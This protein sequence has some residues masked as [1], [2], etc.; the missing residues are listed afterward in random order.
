M[1]NTEH[2]ASRCHALGRRELVLHICFNN[3]V[4][5]FFNNVYK[6][7]R[8]ALGQTNRMCAYL[9]KGVKLFLIAYFIIMVVEVVVSIYFTMLLLL[10]LL[11]FWLL[12]FFVVVVVSIY[13]L[14]PRL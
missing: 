6:L 10:L 9:H 13:Q 4:F 1:L 12:L 11:L 2:N 14:L 7:H 5:Y 3:R 8:R